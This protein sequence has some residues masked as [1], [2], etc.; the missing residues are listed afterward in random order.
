MDEFYVLVQVED[1]PLETFFTRAEAIAAMI[2]LLRG[3]PDLSDELYVERFRLVV[4]E[5]SER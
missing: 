5:P 2:E 4:A 1:G 3:E